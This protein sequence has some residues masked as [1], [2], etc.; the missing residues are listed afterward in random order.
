M[1]MITTERARFSDPLY[2]ADGEARASVSP[3]SL[4]TVW[5]NTG[6]LCNLTCENCYI[7]SSPKNDRLAYLRRD[8]VSAILREIQDESLP[9]VEIGITG[10]EPFMNPEIIGILDD[11]LSAG[12]KVLVLSN[13][14]RPMMK[15]A[16][17]L[18][19]LRDRYPE[20]LCI[21]VSIDHF[22]Q[23]L[24][25][26]ERGRRSWQATLDGLIWLARN[27]FRI[28]VAARTRWGDTEQSL[29]AG[30]AALFS[31][32]DLDLDASDPGV[33]VLF[34]E[35]DGSAEVPEITTACWG[36]LGVDPADMMCASARMVVR[37]KGV[38]DA[39]VVACT[40]LPYEREFSLGSTLTESLQP[41][42]LNHPHCARFCVLG[43]GRCSG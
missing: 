23:R 16:Q 7:E 32:L 28:N 3:R 36:I 39:E 38:R 30:F 31:A 21:R 41:V 40:L 37:R 5:L 33:L 8:D 29:R 19:Q 22:E 42:P 10:G 43:G 1:Q 11:C 26:Q 4:A 34:P 17:G 35:M 15:V 20:K 13:A 18:K 12:F 9:V 24:H 27:G 25:E 6:T 14:M 2:T